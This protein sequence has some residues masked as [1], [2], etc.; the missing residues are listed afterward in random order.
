VDHEGNK[1]TSHPKAWI[2][3]F[4]VDKEVGQGKTDLNFSIGINL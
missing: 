3:D 4:Q 2:S 1:K